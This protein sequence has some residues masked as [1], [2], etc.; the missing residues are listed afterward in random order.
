M[1]GDV[2]EGVREKRS[3]YHDRVEL[4]AEVLQNLLELFDA[5]VGPEFADLVV[6]DGLYLSH[7]VQR[8]PSHL[9]KVDVFD[10]GVPQ[11]I[12]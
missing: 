8:L 5:F 10:V 4:V 9:A 6:I 7:V 11:H 12:N 1:G 3:T 2:L